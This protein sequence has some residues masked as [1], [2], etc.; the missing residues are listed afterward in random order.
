MK[1]VL[2]GTVNPLEFDLGARESS[3][4]NGAKIAHSVPVSDLATSLVEFGH[5]VTVIGV[6]SGLTEEVQSLT[7]HN[8]VKLI[9]VR[10]RRR[11]KVKAICFY[12]LERKLISRQ[13]ALIKPDVIHAHWTYE[14]ALAAQ[15]S[16][17]PY[18]ITVHDEPWE[19]LRSFRNFYRFLR[20][21]VAIRVRM[22]GRD[23][24]TFVSDYIHTLWNQRMFGTGGIVIPNMNRLAISDSN[25]SERLSNVITVGNDGR[26]KNVRSL[27]E[28]WEV[29]L[30][31]NPHLHL[32]IVGPGL[33]IGDSLAKEFQHKF[34]VHQVTWHGPI[35]RDELSELYSRCKVLVHPSRHE[36][37]GL[38]YLE[39]FA[40]KL[41]IIT[42]AKSGSAREIVGDA[43]LILN[44]DSPQ[45]ISR[46]VL[47]LTS[48]YE[49]LDQLTEIGRKRL[50]LYSPDLVT[51]MYIS[52]YKEIVGA[53]K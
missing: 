52:L 33:G 8:G 44:D 36:S 13:I 49:L 21:L 38:I 4:L 26:S 41:G 9:Y 1:I 45:S 29:V 35:T 24:F 2:L 53:F 51:R 14:Y 18:V 27:L 50:E 30:V 48:D 3:W 15:D 5:K 17:L 31:T 16:G 43:G 22:R 25:S 28:A 11:E 40:A 32:H 19:I 20:L 12:S 34:G 7:T 39:A 10:G 23:N 37:F 42:L 47:R 6:I 46:A